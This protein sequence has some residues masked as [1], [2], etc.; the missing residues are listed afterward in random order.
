MSMMSSA[1]CLGFSANAYGSAAD[2]EDSAH[3]WLL[4][5]FGGLSREEGVGLGL[6]VGRAV[7]EGVEQDGR[8][9][10]LE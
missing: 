9:R 3:V 4:D 6:F 1:Q 2:F 5:V 8:D 10:R 7:E